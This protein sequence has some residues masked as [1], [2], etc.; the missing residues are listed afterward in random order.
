MRK[1][2]ETWRMLS[3]LWRAWGGRGQV[4]LVDHSSVAGMSAAHVEALLFGEEHSVVI[5]SVPAPR[6]RSALAPPS[7]HKTVGV[8][9]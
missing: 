3:G 5:I 4:V 2:Q 1:S 7:Q 8:A 9:R 6:A